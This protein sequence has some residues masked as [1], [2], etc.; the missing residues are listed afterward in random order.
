[1]VVLFGALAVVVAGVV[2]DVSMIGSPLNE[3]AGLVTAVV[4]SA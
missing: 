4:W 2:D 1:M 3:R